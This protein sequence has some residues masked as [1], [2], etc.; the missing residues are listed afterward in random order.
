MENTGGTTEALET[1]PEVAVAAAVGAALIPHIIGHQRQSLLFHRDSYEPKSSSNNSIPMTLLATIVATMTTPGVWTVIETTNSNN[2]VF[3][4]RVTN[5][6]C[7]TTFRRR[8]K[9]M[10]FRETEK[11]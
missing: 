6:L 10:S 5:A 2:N 4:D 1:D 7:I 9:Q 3:G 8:E 11:T